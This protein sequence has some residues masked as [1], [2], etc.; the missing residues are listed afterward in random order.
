VPNSMTGYGMADGPV[1]GGRLSVEVRTVNH[2]HFSSQFRLPQDLLRFES[3]LKARL[4]EHIER[5]HATVVARWTEV[6]VEPTAVHVDVDR[7]RVLVEALKKL[8]EELDLQ[9]EI[10]LG[11]VARQPDVL[12][13][14]EDEE[15]EI[16][17]G[18]LLNVLDGAVNDVV[19]MR[20]REGAALAVDLE[21]RLAA[22]EARL[23]EVEERASRRV[24]AERDRLRAAVNDL[25]DGRTLDESRLSQEIAILAD[26]LDIT[27]EMVR[28]RTHFGAFQEALRGTGAVGKQL[29]FLGQ[30]M[31][32]EVNTIGSKANDAEIAQVV[33]A[34]KGELEKV[35]EQVENI[36]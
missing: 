6:S 28:L 29:S 11:F 20:Q 7:A 34:M 1:G 16:D 33:I 2:R 27:E 18:E 12:T 26:K 24:A 19:I 21:Q 30:E 14:A 8:K 3:D 5:G 32:R 10:D 35:R 31:L 15:R 4:R 25:L 22:M 13:H 23:A 17:C 36:E 9:G